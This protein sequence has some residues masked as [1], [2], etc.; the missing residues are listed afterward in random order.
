MSFLI[1]GL[2][3]VLYLEKERKEINR[4]LELLDQEKIDK[5]KPISI[6]VADFLD[7]HASKV[8]LA[9]AFFTT[10]MQALAIFSLTL[11]SIFDVSKVPTGTVFNLQGI[12]DT[13]GNILF[14]IAA[15][16]CLLSYVVRC[17][18]D[19]NG[20][21]AHNMTRL[22][23]ISGIFSGTFLVFAGK[24][25]LSFETRG[26]AIY[27]GNTGPFGM[28]TLPVALIIRTVGMAIF[29]VAYAMMIYCSVKEG[30]ELSDKVHS[31]DCY[32]GLDNDSVCSSVSSLPSKSSMPSML[33]TS[34]T[35]SISGVLEVVDHSRKQSINSCYF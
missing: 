30:K 21:S 7:D 5:K 15:A 10:G 9:G 6:K 23:V 8:D 1:S 12:V 13:V 35:S 25:L 29:C 24:V 28:D 32:N 18:K 22:L 27:T 34:S 33:S 26:G 2:L 19:K 14:T 16:M 4:K 11:P 17:K 20:K 31:Y 3:N